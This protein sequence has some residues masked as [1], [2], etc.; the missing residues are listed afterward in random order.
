MRSVGPKI[1]SIARPCF[2]C[3]GGLK[4]RP[5]CPTCGNTKD[6]TGFHPIDSNERTS[7]ESSEALSGMVN[8][9]TGVKYRVKF[10]YAKDRCR[11]IEEVALIRRG[12]NVLFGDYMIHLLEIKEIE[13]VP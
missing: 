12:P 11:T 9:Q 7:K 8:I 10:E 4:G 5:Y 6:A 2:A 13:V 1:A 3:R